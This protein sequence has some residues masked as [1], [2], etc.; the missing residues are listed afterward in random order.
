MILTVQCTGY[1]TVLID[2]NMIKTLHCTSSFAGLLECIKIQTGPNWSGGIYLIKP[3]HE[4]SLNSTYTVHMV[5]SANCTHYTDNCTLHTVYNAQSTLHSVMHTVYC[6]LHTAQ[7]ALLTCQYAFYTLHFPLLWSAE[8]IK[9][10][11]S[12]QHYTV[13]S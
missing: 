4:R 1:F 2:C 13:N 5:P 7:E 11:S 12:N 3:G 8:L 6:T 9:D 10:C